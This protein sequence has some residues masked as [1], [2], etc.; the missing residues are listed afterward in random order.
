MEPIRV[1]IVDDH[2]MIRR[3][4]RSLLSSFEDIRVVGEASDGATAVQAVS[5]LSPDV[6]LL[7]VQMTGPDGIAVGSRLHKEFPQLRI[8]I[9][10]AYDDDEYIKGALQAGAFAYLLKR[11]SD[12]TVVEAIRQVH[13]GKRFLSPA[14]MDRVLQ[15]YQDVLQDQAKN[16]FGL[17]PEELRVLG[18]IAQG[19]TNDEIAKE[20]YW[21]ERTVKRKVEE[22]M[23]KMGARNRAQAVAEAIKKGVI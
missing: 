1:L 8:I 22:I 9:L 11:S 5:E 19:A 20:M 4:L 17:T 7:D 14:L 21:G 3:G 23:I 13:R 6:L 16:A 15:Q 18:L 2:A 10:S 12:E